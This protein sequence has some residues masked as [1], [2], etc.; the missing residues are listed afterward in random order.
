MKK[1]AAKLLAH[2]VDRKIKMDNNPVEA[3]QKTLKFLVS[4]A[5]N[6][7]FGKDHNF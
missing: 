7:T 3:Q 1:I 2:W 4:S 5:Q 6:T